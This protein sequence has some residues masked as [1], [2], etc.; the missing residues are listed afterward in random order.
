MTTAALV[1]ITAPQSSEQPGEHLSGE[2]VAR[3]MSG[4]S[5]QKSR[6]NWSIERPPEQGAHA[7]R[8][9]RWHRSRRWVAGSGR[10]ALPVTSAISARMVSTAHPM[11]SILGIRRWVTS[12]RA[13]ARSGPDQSGDQRTLQSAAAVKKT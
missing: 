12:L 9:D 11:R 1:S 10:T 2:R 5:G 8:R 6:A 4:S 7:R 13:T 3:G